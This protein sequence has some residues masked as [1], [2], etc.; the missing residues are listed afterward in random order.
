MIFDLRTL[1]KSVRMTQRELSEKSGVPLR[2][3]QDI[4]TRGDCLVST[5]IKLID[6]LDINVESAISRNIDK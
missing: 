6:A 5:M 4:E 1:R 2:T 3:L